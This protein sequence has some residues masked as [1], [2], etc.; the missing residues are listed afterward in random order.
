[1]VDVNLGA[2][3]GQGNIQFLPGLAE[4]WTISPDSTYYNFTLRQNINFSNGDPFNAYQYWMEMYGFY[5]LEANSSSWLESYDLF[6]MTGVNFGPATVALINQSGLINPSPQALAIMENSSWPIYVTGPY[7]IVFHLQSSFSYFLGILVAYSGMVFDT[8][9][10][11]DHGGFGTPTSINS[12]FNQHSIPGTGPYVF[13][14][15]LKIHT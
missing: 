13:L 4:N 7:S 10:V 11:L 6:N 12:Y 15:I 1:M 9:W 3:Y 14:A 2:E 8:Q 5:Y